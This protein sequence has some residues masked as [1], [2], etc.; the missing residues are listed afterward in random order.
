MLE[1]HSRIN[2]LHENGVS[3][4]YRRQ[5]DV[6]MAERDESEL[7]QRVLRGGSSSSG[8]DSGG[9]TQAAQTHREPAQAAQT[10]REIWP[11]L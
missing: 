5:I 11:E 8:C 3:L 10:H 2:T 4:H 1:P 9:P 7:G 6:K